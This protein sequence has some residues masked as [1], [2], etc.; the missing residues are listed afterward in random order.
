[1]SAT[2]AYR[3]NDFPPLDLRTAEGMLSFVDGSEDRETWVAIGMALKSEFGETAFGAWDNW[4]QQAGNYNALACRSSWRGFKVRNG[5]YTIGTL[6]KLAKDG[7]YKFDASERPA[8]DM[9]DIARRRAER[10]ERTASDMAKR[11]QAALNAE[12]VAKQVWHEASRTGV[13]EYAKRKGID[14]PESCRYLPPEQGGGLVIPMLRYDLDRAQALKG[15]Q[16]I[17]DDG[18]KLFTPG[19]QKTGAACRLGLAVVGEPVFVC[20]GYATGMS[21]RMALGRR[22]PVFVAFDAY[23][24]PPVVAAVHQALPTSPIVICA[25]D[26]FKTTNKGL[27]NNVGRIQ[28]QVALESVMDAGARLVCRS[29]PVFKKESA[30]GDKDTDFNDLHRIEGLPEVAAQMQLCLEIIEELRIYG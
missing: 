29:F 4:S 30:R 25:D 3:K 8:P 15:V 7:G 12:E 1:V 24:L 9:A 21:I 5:G 18:R 22:Y 14:A 28:A 23:S 11:Q 17:S 26:D 27:P 6:V 2:P 20:E 16:T 10:A 19:M 13:S